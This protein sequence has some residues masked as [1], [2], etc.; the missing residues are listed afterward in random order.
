MKF[1]VYPCLCARAQERQKRWGHAEGGGASACTIPSIT[2]LDISLARCTNLHGAAWLQ[3]WM[4]TRHS[5]AV[6]LF[7]S[8]KE[9]SQGVLSEGLHFLT[10]RFIVHTL[11]G[12]NIRSVLPDNLHPI[13]LSFISNFFF[14]F[15]W[16]TEKKSLSLCKRGYT[17]WQNW[18]KGEE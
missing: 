2:P 13:L 16:E 5:L 1:L 10:I 3:G 15:F 6:L 7:Q 9:L 12:A 18:Q 14:F 4:G 8:T 17:A 11:W